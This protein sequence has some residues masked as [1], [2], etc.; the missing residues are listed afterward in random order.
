VNIQGRL[1]IKLTAAIAT[2]R[3]ERETP[4]SVVGITNMIE[5][6][7][8]VSTK[9]DCLFQLSDVRNVCAVWLAD[10]ATEEPEAL[11]IL[12]GLNLSSPSL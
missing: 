2:T 7:V 1:T 11:L 9:D 8:T 12:S 10:I 5:L 6:E 4:I 3:A